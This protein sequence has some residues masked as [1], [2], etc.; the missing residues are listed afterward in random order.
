MQLFLCAISSCFVFVFVFL[1]TFRAV[2]GD[3]VY[4]LIH[5]RM[6]ANVG[7]CTRQEHTAARVTPD[8]MVSTARYTTFI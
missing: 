4:A 5:A 7:T 3:A 1:E 6:A 2:L 8:S